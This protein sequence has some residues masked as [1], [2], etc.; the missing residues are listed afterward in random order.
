MNKFIAVLFT[1]IFL[2][3][4]TSKP[5][6]VAPVIEQFD[7]DNYL[8]KWYE[9]VRLPHSFEED[10]ERVTAE[11]RLNSDGTL[12]VTNRGYNVELGE[13]ET[14]IGHA[15]PVGTAMYKVTFFWPFYGGYYISELQ[16]NSA[17][18]YTLAVITSDSHDYFWVLAR[19]P[20]IPEAMLE[21][22]LQK[23]ENWGYDTSLMIRVNHQAGYQ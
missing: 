20:E 14:A 22:L 11:Y 2:F 6:P 17:G 7:A 9:I 3:G 12:E 23:A 1:S 15:K 18:K 10:L 19:T 13:W 5:A 4:C 21:E 16:S 8:G